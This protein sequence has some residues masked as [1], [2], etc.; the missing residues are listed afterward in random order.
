MAV[1]DY[2]TYLA[3]EHGWALHYADPELARE[4]ATIILHGSVRGLSPQEALAVAITT[5]GLRHRLERGELVVLRAA[6][7]A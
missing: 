2:L 1:H 6:G 4:A 3:R 7:E 5:S